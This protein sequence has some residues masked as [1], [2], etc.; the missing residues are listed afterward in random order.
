MIFAAATAD[1]FVDALVDF[2]T[3]PDL[4]F[5]V[6]E[7]EL[8]EVVTVGFVAVGLLVDSGRSVLIACPM[9][10]SLH[11]IIKRGSVE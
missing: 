5:G 9:A 8:S 4:A 11:I 10:T 1:T 3:P 7:V 6:F 2:F